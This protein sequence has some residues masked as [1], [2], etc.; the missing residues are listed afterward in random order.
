MHPYTGDYTEQRKNEKN[1]FTYYTFTP[2]PL[3]DATLYKMDNELATFLIEAHHNLGQ[4][5]GLFQYAP[6]KNSFCELMLLKECT[7]SRMIDYDAPNFSDILVRRG[8][9]K[10]DMEPINNLL[11]AY[12]AADGMQFTAQDY[13][14]ICSIAL[15]G[16]KPEQQMGVRDIQTFLQYAISNLKTYNP[17]APEAVLPSLADISAYLYDSGDDPLIQAALAHY[18]FEMIHPFEKYNGIVGR[19]LIFMVL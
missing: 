18:Q 9:G 19:I 13:S 3:K 6:N 10:G 15:Y 2:R 12:K 14:K 4:L 11:A 17:T 8:T 5:E 1:N 16:D 7:Y